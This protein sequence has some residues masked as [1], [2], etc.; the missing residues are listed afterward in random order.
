MAAT[1]GSASLALVSSAG[2]KFLQRR[3]CKTFPTV[4]FQDSWR[5][6]SA[7]EALKRARRSRSVIQPQISLQRREP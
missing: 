2:N 1:C 5:D 6:E 7:A 4:F 3:A